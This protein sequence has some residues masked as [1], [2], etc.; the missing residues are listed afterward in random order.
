MF[1]LLVIK[2][3]TQTQY[4]LVFADFQCKS[5]VPDKPGLQNILTRKV[6]FPYFCTAQSNYVIGFS[7]RSANSILVG[8]TRSLNIHRLFIY[9]LTIQRPSSLVNNDGTL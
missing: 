7:H 3:K 5:D 9:L 4:Y 2:K 8:A 6:A 1:P